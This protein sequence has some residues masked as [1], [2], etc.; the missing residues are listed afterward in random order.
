MGKEA[1]KEY[2][3]I[4]ILSHFRVHLK[5]TY[6]ANQLYFNKNSYKK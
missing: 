3:Y 2:A 5:L 6:T 4:H 1:E